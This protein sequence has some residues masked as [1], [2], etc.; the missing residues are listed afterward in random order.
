M[1]SADGCLML[2]IGTAS[3]LIWYLG[4]WKILGM[5]F[6]DFFDSDQLG[7]DADRSTCY[8]HSD[9]ESRRI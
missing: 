3:S 9:P 8:L 1:L 7:H 2:V 4:L 6:L 5:Q